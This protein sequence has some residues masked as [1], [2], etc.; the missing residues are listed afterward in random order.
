LDDD[1]LLS[2]VI[3]IDHSISTKQQRYGDFLPSNN[4]ELIIHKMKPSEYF[5]HSI[6]KKSHQN[7]DEI[8]ISHS[9]DGLSR[10]VGL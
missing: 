2:H 9:T 6:S 10:R 3:P 7:D 8:L 5:R 4:N 1:T